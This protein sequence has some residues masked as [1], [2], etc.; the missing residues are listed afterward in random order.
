MIISVPNTG[1]GEATVTARRRQAPPNAKCR[2]HLH[3]PE[4]HG[5]KARSREQHV[6][7]LQEVQL[8]RR[9]HRGEMGAMQQTEGAEAKDSGDMVR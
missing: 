7:K 5:L 3:D 8:Q 6:P 4:L 1:R 2:P 9:Y